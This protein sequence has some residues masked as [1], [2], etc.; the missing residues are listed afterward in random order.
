M[1]KHLQLIIENAI[2]APS[3]HNTQ[4]W[5]FK[6]DEDHI[7]IRPD[8]TRSLP[9]TDPDNHELFISLGCALENLVIAAD[10]YGYEAFAM[11]H[12]G[13]DASIDVSLWPASRRKYATL[14]SQINIRQSTRNEYDGRVIPPDHLAQ[15]NASI[16]HEGVSCRIITEPYMIAAVT[17]LAKEACMR[18]FTN[19]AFVDEL[20]HW[21]RFNQAKAEKTQDGLYSAAVGSPSV[22][23]WFGKFIMGNTVSPEHEAAKCEKLIRSSSA[24]V[25]FVAK[26]NTLA[27]WINVGRAFER[28]T[29]TASALGIHNAPENMPCQEVDVREKLARLLQL[30][31]GEQPLMLVRIG[32]SAKMPYSYRRPINE[33]VVESSRTLADPRGPL[34]N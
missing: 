8:F 15:L 17:E 22:P 3:G 9:V 7:T 5:K 19:T 23:D 16:S 33:V 25:V 30:T 32:Y 26:Q 4:P 2:K 20:V 1:E 18:Q 14:F 31:E 12:E 11:A 27:N 10:H 34:A 6:V 13:D 29:L 28:F 21:I 24:L